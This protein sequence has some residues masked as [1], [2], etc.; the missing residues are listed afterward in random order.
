LW[1]IAER[2]ADMQRI[3]HQFEPFAAGI[4]GCTGDMLRKGYFQG[5]LF[6]FPLRR[7]ASELSSTIYERERVEALMAQFKIDARILLLF[8]KNITSIEVCVRNQGCDNARVSFRVAISRSCQDEI[9]ICR[10]RLTDAV[11]MRA[12]QNI[13]ITYLLAVDVTEFNND[14]ASV[15]QNTFRYLVNEYYAG[16]QVSKILTQLR[17][18]ASLSLI[19]VVGTALDMDNRNALEERPTPNLEVVTNEA[20]EKSREVVPCG[21][22]FCSLPLAAQE[23]SPTG[24]PVH[25]NGY[26]AVSQNRQHL[27]WPASG[28]R[29]ESDKCLLWNQCLIGDLVPRSYE[30][31][32]LYAIKSGHCGPA[33]IYATLPDMMKVDEKWQVS[34]FYMPFS[35]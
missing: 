12:A 30:D 17:D 5:T 23:K 10:R 32:V 27:K 22:I 11:K 24:L 26:F 15:T 35:A 21:H 31:L 3:P 18:D 2:Q 1:N 28:Q 16:G 33:D 20:D 14:G 13:S 25:V 8:L 34:F 19:P 6:R 4:C 7:M 29:I 9:R